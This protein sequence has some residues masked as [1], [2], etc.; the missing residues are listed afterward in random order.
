MNYTI[1]SFAADNWKIARN[2]ANFQ[3]REARKRILSFNVI[4]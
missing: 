2:G 3:N 1:A 4:Q